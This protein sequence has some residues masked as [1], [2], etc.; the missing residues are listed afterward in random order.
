MEPLTPLC[1]GGL[2][3]FLK[4]PFRFD[5]F[6]SEDIIGESGENFQLLTRRWI[7]TGNTHWFELPKQ[8]HG[9]SFLDRAKLQDCHI[10]I[11]DKH[12]ENLH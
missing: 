4:H 10:K 5:Y 12:D 1:P 11:Q 9:F 7:D 2:A 3:I 8:Q 6:G